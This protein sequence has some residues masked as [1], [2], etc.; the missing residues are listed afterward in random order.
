LSARPAEAGPPRDVSGTA[1]PLEASD[2]LRASDRLPASDPLRATEALDALGDANRRAI[3]R[4]LSVGGQSVKEIADQLPISR[5]AVSRHLRLL[6]G[7]G[8]VDDRPD[9][10]RHVYELRAEGVEAIKAYF[11]EVWDNAASRFRLVAENTSTVTT[12]E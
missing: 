7:A 8:L 6:K 11:A 5:P 10:T 2:P 12:D 4:I 3:V 9:G 1:E